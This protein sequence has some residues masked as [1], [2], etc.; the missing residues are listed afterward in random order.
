MRSVRAIA[1]WWA[2]GLAALA[3]PILPAAGEDKAS[4]TRP[5]Q[6]A[7]IVVDHRCLDVAKIPAAAID[8]AKREL[9]VAYWH[10]SHGS[11]VVS[12][13][14]AMA[15][16]R[17]AFDPA[18]KGGALTLVEWPGDLGGDGDSKWAQ[19][20]R[21][22]L[23]GS[24]A[25]K[26]VV[27]WSWCWGVGCN[28]ETGIRGYLDEMKKL[29]AEFPKVAFVRMTGHVNGSGVD[30]VLNR[31]NEQIRQGCKEAK[32][33][34]FDFADVESFDPDG[35]SFLEKGATEDC[36]YLKP[37][38]AKGNW[39]LEWIARHPDHGWKLP[40]SAAHTQPL[41]GAMKGRAFWWLLARLAGWNGP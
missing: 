21:E 6:G 17:F 12:G 38:G 25:D 1:R 22:R 40:S 34:L 13:M 11:Q 39:A 4:E 35:N 19:A 14:R 5:G 3:A 37:D 28:T 41:N 33:V 10:T 24:D 29:E 15:D 7:A 20:T 16:A 23:R 9:R 26:N 32:A 2:A 18:G 27:V 30:G 36:S 8:K 31:R